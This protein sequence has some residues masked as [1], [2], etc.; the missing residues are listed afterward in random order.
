MVDDPSWLRKEL[1]GKE[2]EIESLSSQLHD[3]HEQNASLRVEGVKLHNQVL[4]EREKAESA[5]LRGFKM[6]YE[7]AKAEKGSDRVFHD[8][9]RNHFK[10]EHPDWTVVCKI[11]DR[12]YDDIV[13]DFVEVTQVC[14]DCGKEIDTKKAHRFCPHCKAGRKVKR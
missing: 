2:K 6:G 9:I 8:H 5:K 13:N 12:S 7:K 14:G 4:K 10:D 11:C 1:A 3:L